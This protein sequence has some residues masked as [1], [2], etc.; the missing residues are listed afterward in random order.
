LGFAAGFDEQCIPQ[1]FEHLFMLDFQVEISLL[2]I[3]FF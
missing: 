1:A 2:E 3:I